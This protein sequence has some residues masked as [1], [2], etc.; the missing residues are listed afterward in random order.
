[1]ILVTGGAGYIGSH[2]VVVLLA[3]HHHCVIFDNLST[4][5]RETVTALQRL[6]PEYCGFVEGDLCCRADVE[7]AFACRPEAVIHFAAF[8][9]VSVSQRDPLGYYRNNVTGTVNLLQTMLAHG[10]KLMVF[11]SSAAVY[12]EARQ[13]P[14]TETHPCRPINPYGKTKLMIEQIMDD[15]DRA[16]GLRSVRLRYFNVAGADTRGI[17]GEWHEPETHL[18]PNIL[19]AG[20]RQGHPLRLFG[21]DY[22]TRDGTCVRDYV[23]V[24]DLAR[25]HLLAL[26]Y[27]RRDGK[28]AAFNLGTRTGNTVKEIVG[29]C[30]QALDCKIPVEIC[31]RRPGDPAVLVADNIAASTV[32]GWT[33][34]KTLADSIKTAIAWER[35]R[36]SARA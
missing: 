15:C 7:R 18:I 4:G 11:S 9:Q 21:T 30:E 1:M 6:A 35:Q 29:I 13:I 17:V 16:Y 3:Q 33:P 34:Q 8:S 25:A 19:K 12:G 28:T 20:S 26:D 14:I 5:H 2:C 31:P 23:N 24:E 36:Q 10:V 32:L 22:A 27:L